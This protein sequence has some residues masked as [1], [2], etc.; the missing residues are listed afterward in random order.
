ITVTEIDCSDLE[1][2]SSTGA[3]VTCKGSVTL[4]ATA[5]G[6]GTDIYWYDAA[7]N[8]N[9][10]GMGPVYT[11]DEL[12]TTT[13]FWASAVL[14]DGQ[15]P[16]TG[17]GKPAPTG[18]AAFASTLNYGLQFDVNQHFTLIS[19]DV[20]PTAGGSL[21]ISLTDSSGNTL[22]SVNLN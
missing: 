12:T 4:T 15:A 17:Q 10:I 22:D 13:S 19:V 21:Q 2:I 7:V 14:I 11:T 6:H 16:L 3:T 8:G 5:S 20:Y 1:I 9:R 18:T